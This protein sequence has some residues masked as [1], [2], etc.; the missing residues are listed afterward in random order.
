[1]ASLNRVGGVGLRLKISDGEQTE[2]LAWHVAPGNQI[3]FSGSIKEWKGCHD[4][5]A[6][7]RNPS[8]AGEPVKQTDPAGTDRST[9][10]WIPGPWAE[11]IVLLPHHTLGKIQLQGVL[12]HAA[13]SRTTDVFLD[14]FMP[15]KHQTHLTGQERHVWSW[16]PSGGRTA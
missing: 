9:N 3:P 10:R 15:Q 4:F 5:G 1:M 12:K 6:D 14:V 13:R 7:C 8:A 2:L 11:A 16:N